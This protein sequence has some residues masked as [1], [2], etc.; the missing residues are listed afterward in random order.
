MNGI[1]ILSFQIFILAFF[2]G[3]AGHSFAATNCEANFVKFINGELPSDISKNPIGNMWD[4]RFDAFK[5]AEELSKHPEIDI[6]NYL[7][8]LTKLVHKD[9]VF[10]TNLSDLYSKLYQDKKISFKFLQKNLIN[11]QFEH[12]QF[13]YSDAG[14]SVMSKVAIDPARAS[15]VDEVL[16]ST[17]LS[18]YYQD[19]YRNIF[20]TSNRTNDELK[21]AFDSGL[22]LNPNRKDLEQF[23]KFME[24]ID[25]VK[26]PKAAKALKRVND[27]FDYDRINKVLSYNP[28]QG[29]IE[30]F[31]AQEKRVANYTEK[32][33]K[34]LQRD[35]KLQ[36]KSEILSEIDDA[37]AREAR[38]EIVDPREKLRF[39]KKI[40]DYELPNSHKIRARNQA[41]HE[42]K[43]YRKLLNGCGG[44]DSQRLK[45]ATKKFKRFKLF[46]T[47]GVS[48]GI[49][50]WKN[51]DQIGKDPDI[52]YKFGY[53]VA[54][55]LFFT[56]VGNKIFTKTNTSFWNK[57]LE[58]YWKFS[59]MS[60]M[61]GTGY[62]QLFGEKHMVRHLQK[63][64][65]GDLPPTQIEEEFEKLRSSPTFEKDMQELLDF[66]EEKSKALSTRNVLDRYFHLSAYSSLDDELRITQEDLE[67]EEAR[68]MVMELMAERIYLQNM[69]TVPFFQ[70]GK[71]GYDR[72]LFY[73]T[74]NILWDMKGIMLNLAIFEL[75]CRQP[76]GKIGSWGAIIAMV[77]GDN[78]LDNN[79]TLKL[80][81]EMINQ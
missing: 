3:L 38:G 10:N 31:F 69:G 77:L 76:F 53:E 42:G 4:E 13:F 48:P 19:E 40:D 75:M 61:D 26:A 34:E 2:V 46:L 18:Q 70:T 27:I 21:L 14:R 50:L 60:F 58:G 25:G 64:F 16:A 15:F 78:I 11:R 20:M 65:R 49:F 55:G 30:K 23:K 22:K 71:K 63:I 44:G 37:I 7:E 80:R 12:T 74:R 29:Q 9:K 32:R 1:K 62:E 6:N 66:L 52:M 41:I 47:L 72:F 17:K 36:Q 45:A 8:E 33:L 59:I 43:I 28:H 57:Y 67:S 73:R 81:R 24:F 68:E 51:R 56:V 35:L 79:F 54:M 5:V 39:G